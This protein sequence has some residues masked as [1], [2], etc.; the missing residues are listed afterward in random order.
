MR[1][2]D[3][4]GKLGQAKK[5]IKVFGENGQE[6]CNIKQKCFHISVKEKSHILTPLRRPLGDFSNAA[7]VSSLKAEIRKPDA[8]IPAR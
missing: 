8:A 5:G 6:T 3:L 1:K 2:Y 7:F 4:F